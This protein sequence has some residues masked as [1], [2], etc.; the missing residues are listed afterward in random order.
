MGLEL[1]KREVEA[2]EIERNSRVKRH[3]GNSSVVDP[4]KHFKRGQIISLHLK[5]FVT[6]DDVVLQASPQLNL[7]AAPNGTGK[8]TI[9][10]ALCIVFCVNVKILERASS[11][12]EFIKRGTER[13]TVEVDLYEPKSPKTNFI[14]HVSRTFDKNRSDSCFIDGKPVRKAE[15]TELC[16]SLK[17]QLE[18]LCLF[19]PQERISNFTSMEPKELFRRTLEATSGSEL[20]DNFQTLLNKEEELKTQRNS[21]NAEKQQLVQL[22]QKRD[23]FGLEVNVVEEAKQ[24]EKELEEMDAVR[25]W[26]TY[27]EDRVALLLLEEEKNNSKT[28]RNEQKS[29][30]EGRKEELEQARR[31]L[32]EST[33]ELDTVYNKAKKLMNE[34]STLLERL[35]ELR[36]SIKRNIDKHRNHRPDL[37]KRQRE[38]QAMKERIAQIDEELRNSP[39]VEHLNRKVSEVKESIRSVDTVK[40]DFEDRLGRQKSAV[41]KHEEEINNLKSKEQHFLN[42]R[43]R[44]LDL[45]ERQSRNIKHCVE[46]V[47]KNRH[48]FQ[49][50]VFGPIGLEIQVN[51]DY[52]AR[53]LEACIPISLRRMF[54]VES[55]AD[56][57]LLRDSVCFGIPIDCVCIADVP[58]DLLSLLLISTA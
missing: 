44:Q 40:E 54:V 38:V 28:K 52:H 51:E 21:Q 46:L 37:E 25:G 26:L 16:K 49:G 12:Q 6:F 32:E 5:N 34:R 10:S 24:L 27:E 36:N 17:I 23:E 47:E 33:M 15:V 14:R 19:L 57:D 20:L 22:Q 18:N 43:L 8:S 1:M 55:S 3:A 4:Y 50:N 53:I 13:A 39:S 7:I 31:E 48:Q 2:P 42:F 56:F 41:R 35:K 45:L 9:A 30:L 29:L 58:K 11:L